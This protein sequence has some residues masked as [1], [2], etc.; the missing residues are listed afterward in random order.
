MLQQ[1]QMQ[2][3]PSAG[4]NDRV[5]SYQNICNILT[6]SVSKAKEHLAHLAP[7]ASPPKG[8]KSTNPS[9][10][11]SHG[12]TKNE[13][14]VKAD[15]RIQ[16]QKKQFDGLMKQYRKEQKLVE[17]KKAFDRDRQ[18]KMMHRDQ[19]IKAIKQRK[20]EEEMVCHQRSQMFK[21]NAQQVRLCKKVYKLASDLEK[22][23]L[24]EEKKQYKENEVKKQGQK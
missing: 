4:M 17:A 21:R 3:A 14:G 5:Q 8:R 18:E 23:K 7:G 9:P 13:A 2:N 10:E 15:E 22:N 11:R 12:F 1:Q 6:E 16:K 24:L 19:K 20:F